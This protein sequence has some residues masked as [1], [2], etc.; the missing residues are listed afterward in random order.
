VARDVEQRLA[1]D[2]GI[3][4]VEGK[5]SF[6]VDASD[7]SIQIILLEISSV[8]PPFELAERIGG[9]FIEL[10]EARELPQ[11]EL[12]LLRKAYEFLLGG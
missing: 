5:F 9:S 1:L 3:L 10:L 4:K 6:A 8:D 11:I 7:Q 12:D 2:E